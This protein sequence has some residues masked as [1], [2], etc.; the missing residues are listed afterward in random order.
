MTKYINTET[1]EI[2]TK[3]AV[4]DSIKRT[5][6]IGPNT[7]SELNWIAVLPASKPVPS[8][9]L[10][11]VTGNG[12]T[13][14]SLDNWVEAYIERDMFQDT[15]EDGV[16]TTKAEHEAAYMTKLFDERK[17]QLIVKCKAD[18]DAKTHTNETIA[19]PVDEHEI[20][21]ENEVDIRNL[22]SKM[23]A[24]T[25]IIQAGG[26]AGDY[27]YTTVAKVQ[28]TMTVQQFS[29]AALSIMAIKD[30]IFYTY[31]DLRVLIAAATTGAALDTIE[32]DWPTI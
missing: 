15:Q 20:K 10:K 27:K 24:A 5:T 6:S 29:T 28:V 11:I 18:R 12:V 17:A 23:V 21:T 9:N 3:R 16:T 30:A 26:G 8:S 2:S 7:L 31:E 19:F 22:V 25:A 13:Q 4:I 14:D 32:A 1:Q